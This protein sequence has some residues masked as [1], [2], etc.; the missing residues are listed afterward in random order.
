M[1][2][3]TVTEKVQSLHLELENPTEIKAV[4]LALRELVQTRSS[5]SRSYGYSED[6]EFTKAAKRLHRQVTQ[7]CNSTRFCSVASV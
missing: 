4:S 2:R 6:D 7:T 3:I 1:S 5:L